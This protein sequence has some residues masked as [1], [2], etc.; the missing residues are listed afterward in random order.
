MKR[1]ILIL[2]FCLLSVSVVAQNFKGGLRVGF[3]GTQISGDDLSG[4]NKMGAYAGGFVNWRFPNQPKWAVQMEINFIMK[5]SSKFLI[6]DKDGNIGDK[7]VLTMCY[8]ETPFLAKFN[9]IKGLEIELGPSINFLVYAVEKDANGIIPGRQQFRLG[10][11]SAIGGITYLFK[12]HYGIN[13]RYSQSIIPVRVNDG[14]HGDYRMN[15]KQF[16]SAIAF[17]LFYQF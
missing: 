16:N 14:Y 7:Y 2:I 4:F 10:E 15:K 11:L 8:T 6:A 17:S 1:N 3:T 13:L 9:I 12:E 5:G